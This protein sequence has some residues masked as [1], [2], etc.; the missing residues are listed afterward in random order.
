MRI[1]SYNIHS[2]KDINGQNSLDRVARLIKEEHITIAGF[3]EI[4]SFSLR[5]G[6]VNQPRKL[7]RA[8][9]MISC[10]G[11][12]LRLR[13]IGFFGNAL[14]SRYPIIGHENLKLPGFTGREPR[15]CLKAVLR[16]PGGYLTVLLTHLTLNAADRKAQVETLAGLVKK[17]DNP[18]ILMGDFNCSTA[19][20]QPLEETMVDAGGKFGSLGTY[21]YGNPTHRID[22]IFISPDIT[23]TRFHIPNCDASDH[24]PIVA[25][26]RLP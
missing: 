3:N 16:V 10:Y 14:L 19:E 11:P 7:A 18:V 13:P 5:T 26:L 4:E 23:C 8:R 21:P 6:F 24:L 1:M 17:E 20:L 2:C 25:D 9:E 12:T 22:Y 15:C